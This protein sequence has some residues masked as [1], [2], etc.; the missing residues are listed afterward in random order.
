VSASERAANNGLRGRG[1]QFTSRSIA[2][3]TAPA[4]SDRPLSALPSP[5]ARAAAF[6][7]ILLAGLAGGLI[8]YSLVHLECDGDC[9]LALG[10]G[11]LLGA[12]IAAAGM[13]VV[14]VLV[15]RAV[16]EWR[17]LQDRRP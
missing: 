3:V 6:V 15:L 9:G 11:I 12:V 4:S 1:T 16:G 13:S 14:T 2:G 5:A 10:V 7:A 8:G 17:E